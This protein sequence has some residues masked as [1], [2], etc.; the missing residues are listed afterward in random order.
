L[1][2]RRLIAEDFGAGAP[3]GQI[4][5]VAASPDGLVL[6]NAI[7]E[8][9][10]NRLTIILRETVAPGHDHELESIDGNFELVQLTWLDAATLALVV[11]DR[12]LGGDQM[13]RQPGAPSTN[14]SLYILAIDG[15]TR[16][17]YMDRLGCVLSRLSFSPNRYFAIGQGDAVAVPVIL[18]AH[19]QSCHPLAVRTPI[20]ILGWA[21]DSSAFI[22]APVVDGGSAG[23]VFRFDMASAQ[24]TLVTLSSSAAAYANDGTIV[25]LGS[26]ALSLRRIGA[27][28]GRP[29][30][31]EIALFD[32]HEHETRI[33][34]LGVL[35]LPAM[36][37]DSAMVFSA[38]SENAAID[39][40]LAGQTGPLREVIEYSYP[41]R[42][43]FVLAAGAK[44]GP[45][46]MSWSPDG[47]KLVL[48]DGNA[49]LRTLTVL[50]PPK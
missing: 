15:R 20:R 13:D 46:M 48:I 50:V 8:P 16:P 26:T 24:S 23:A 25:A 3:G 29:V 2:N 33:N 17:R 35:T 21:P 42:A 40:T 28:P 1:S 44:Q 39:L 38:A 14:S 32:P 11:R 43:A 27:A 5:D 45:L 47:H 30:K 22:Y 12:G 18:D 41:A 34:S 10:Q 31:V 7:A 36:L 49:Q 6:A 37:A 19:D 9:A 4:V